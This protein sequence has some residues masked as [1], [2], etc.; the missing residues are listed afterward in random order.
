VLWAAL[1]APALAAL[2]GDAASVQADGVHMK[3][4][5]RVTPSSTFSV[6]QISS[7]AGIVV[8]EFVG[9][10]GKVFAVSWS[11]PLNPD[12]RQVLGGYY[13]QFL[14]AA[15][16]TPINHRQLRITSRGWCRTAPHARLRR[17]RLYGMLPQ[18]F[19]VADIK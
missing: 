1:A 5:V 12:L 15:A 17:A 19:S 11:G 6:H 7:A 16:T 8:R 13:G 2:G 18:N 4:A 3:A 9:T 10:D 14:Q